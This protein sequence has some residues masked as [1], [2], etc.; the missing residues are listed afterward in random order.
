MGFLS[1][2]SP[3]LPHNRFLL[4]YVCFLDTNSTT[5]NAG[6]IPGRH[7]CSTCLCFLP[8]TSFVSSDSAADSALVTIIT[9]SFELGINVDLGGIRGFGGQWIMY[10]GLSLTMT[11]RTHSCYELCW[12]VSR[13]HLPWDLFWGCAGEIIHHACFTSFLLNPTELGC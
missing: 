5:S 6:I 3:P 11:N 9:Y 8:F 12:R 10:N 1:V 7:H 2:T 4:N 13:Q